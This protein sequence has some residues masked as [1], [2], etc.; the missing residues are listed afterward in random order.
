M[1]V[2][3]GRIIIV[4][5]L[6]LMGM[7]ALQLANQGAFFANGFGQAVTFIQSTIE[8]PNGAYFDHVVIIMMEN[9]GINDICNGNPP[10]CSGSNSPYMSSF[11]NN[12]GISQQYLPL[13]STSEPNYYGILGASIFGCPSNCYPPAGGSTRRIL[14][15]GLRLWVCHG[16]VTWRIRMLRQAVMVQ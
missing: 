3:H 9:E 13:I 12:N 5:I 7:S 16:R 15:T 11:A 2:G 10:P 8:A 6:A 14:L 4:F 1:M